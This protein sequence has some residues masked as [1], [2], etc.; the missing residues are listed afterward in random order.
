MHLLLS[1][2]M[3]WI[4]CDFGVV[5]TTPTRHSVIPVLGHSSSKCSSKHIGQLGAWWEMLFPVVFSA[6]IPC[7]VCCMLHGFIQEIG[8]IFR[9]NQNLLN[10]LHWFWHVGPQLC[11]NG[12]IPMDESKSRN[13]QEK[14]RIISKNLYLLFYHLIFWAQQKVS[15]HWF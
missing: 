6:V 10:G 1:F 13:W 11:A 8:F 2:V 12:W 5:V 3:L 14:V 15:V 7:D 9:E 4:F